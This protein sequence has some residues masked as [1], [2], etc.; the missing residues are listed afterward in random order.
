MA[1]PVVAMLTDFGLADHYVAAMKGVVLTGCPEATLVDITHE[2]A[3]HDVRGAALELGACWRYFPPSTV[4]LVVVDPGVGTTR[5]GIAADVGGFRFV[6][7]DNGVLSVVF[8]SGIPSQVVAL[9]GPRF[10]R[11]SMSRTFEG[12]DRFAPAASW[13][14]SGIPLGELGV[15]I[16]D[17]IRLELPQAQTRGDHV[18][19]CVLRVDRFGNV[20]T[21]VPQA[22]LARIL[23]NGSATAV[24]GGHRITRFVETY[25]E[26]PAG[27]VCG[28]IGSRDWL[29][30]SVN[31][32][33]AS[34]ALGVGAGAEVV[35]VT[36]TTAVLG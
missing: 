27:E 15:P 1:R 12:R 18:A 26:M 9:G 14:A 33:R 28:L 3:A 23:C 22:M 25:G 31:G 32:G 16:D 24:V 11:M 13:L 2:I 17:P 7:P 29:E 19:G 4:F 30:L 20:I 10:E 6:A 35:V 34:D 8:D 21:N 36:S 5:R